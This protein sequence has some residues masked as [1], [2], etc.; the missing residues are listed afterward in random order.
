[1]G[2]QTTGAIYNNTGTVSITLGSQDATTDQLNHPITFQVKDIQIN[3]KIA[4]DT[5]KT[6]S[7]NTNNSGFITS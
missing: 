5:S 6:I 1:M 2:T 3:P 7:G 4:V